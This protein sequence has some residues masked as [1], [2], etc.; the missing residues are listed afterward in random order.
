MF[1]R[2]GQ[3]IV[4]YAVLIALVVGAAVAMQTYVKRGL[5]GKVKDAVDHDGIAGA[6][7]GDASLTFKTKQYE[8]YYTESKMDIDTSKT[9]SEDIKK[10]GELSRK[11][12]LEART[13][14]TGSYEKTL[15]TANA[16]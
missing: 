12:S 2:K 13:I 16:D 5:Q 10:E 1:N 14:D 6:T 15:G 8:P 9:Y 4:E 7:I 3:N 11:G